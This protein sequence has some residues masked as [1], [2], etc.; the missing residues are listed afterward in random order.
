MV[1]PSPWQAAGSRG[2]EKPWTDVCVALGKEGVTWEDHVHLMRVLWV[3]G[4]RTCLGRGP[5]SAPHTLPPAKPFPSVHGERTSMRKATARK[6]SFELKFRSGS[7]IILC[8]LFA[9][10]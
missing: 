8:I 4:D 2:S 5:V 6:T 7:K 3:A 10:S 1:G 9:I